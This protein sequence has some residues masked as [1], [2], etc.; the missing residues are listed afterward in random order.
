MKYKRT[1]PLKTPTESPAVTAYQPLVERLPEVDWVRG[2]NVWHVVHTKPETCPPV[3]V[4]TSGATGTAAG[5]ASV[6]GAAVG[7]ARVTGGGGLA[8][9]A[10]MAGAVGGGTS[11]ERALQ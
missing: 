7:T 4:G 8:G 6:T 10:G 2:L 9:V 3:V 11:A 1:Q 5:T